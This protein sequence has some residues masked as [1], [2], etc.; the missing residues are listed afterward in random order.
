MWGGSANDS[1]LYQLNLTTFYWSIINTTGPVPS[2]RQM[3]PYFLYKNYFYIL[4]GHSHDMTGLSLDCY[5]V[6]LSSFI[7][8]KIECDLNR[9]VYAF[10]HID[11]QIALLGGLSDTKITNE[12]L[13]G[14]ITNDIQLSIITSYWVFPP[15]RIN[16]SLHTS[17]DSLWLFGGEYDGT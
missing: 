6:L 7:W 14:N 8:E 9:V 2:P 12:L 15:R 13:V 16:H 5:R 3:F 1:L 11:D 10:C 17:R 4:P